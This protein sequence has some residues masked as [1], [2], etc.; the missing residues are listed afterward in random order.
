MIPKNHT[1]FQESFPRSMF[2]NILMMALTEV[3]RQTYKTFYTAQNKKI[4][5]YV[6]FFRNNIHIK[7]LD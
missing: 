5:K 3:Q 1:S 6:F 4:S 2:L 7:I